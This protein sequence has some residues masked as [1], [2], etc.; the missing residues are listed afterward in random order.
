MP[1]NASSAPIGSWIGTGRAPR[2]STIDCTD[3]GEVGADAV[4][5]VDEDDARHG[6]LVGLAPDGLRLR[7]HAGD[8]VE[9]RDR[10]VEHAQRPLDLDRKVNV[11]GSVDDVDAM[12]TPERGR[13]GRRDRDAALLLLGHP[14]HR[15]RALV[16]LADLV[17]LA[18]VEQDALGRRGLAGVD[19]GHDPDVADQLKLIHL[20]DACV[21]LCLRL[22]A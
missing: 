8:G 11:A 21:L 19:V 9:Q 18:R 20:R 16:H 10:A 3:G 7:L 14:V 15:R 6:V 17:R 4:H 12:V 22:G 2:R 1:S 5:L 13:R